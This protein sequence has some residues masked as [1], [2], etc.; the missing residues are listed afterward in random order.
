MA[1]CVIGLGY[2][3]LTLSLKLVDSG[4]EVYGL[5]RNPEIVQRLLLG[6]LHINEPGL[7][8]LLSKHLGKGF[9]PSTE[10]PAPGQASTHI[11]CVNTPV[12]RRA[13]PDLMPLKEAARQVSTFISRG[14]LVVVRSTIPPGC[15]RSVVLPQLER[16]KMRCG[17]DLYL[18][19]APERTV[20]GQ[21]LAELGKL[22][23]IIGGLDPR[24]ALKA[25]RFFAKITPKLRVVSS[26]E[27]AEMTKL[28]DNSYR[29]ATFAI[30]NELGLA[31]EAMGLDGE[32]VI[33]AA[34]WQYPRN[35]IKLPGAGVGG[36]CLPKDSAILRHAMRRAGISPRILEAARQVN[37]GMPSKVLQHIDGFH[38][39]HGIRP[40]DS[41]ILVLGFAFKG[42]PKVNDTRHSPGGALCRMLVEK[43]YG[44]W[45]YDPAV[46]TEKIR[47]FGAV[48]CSTVEEGFSRA[49]CIV[50]MN[51]NPMWSRL[52]LD[53]L[54][55]LQSNSS[56][57]MDGWRV[58]REPGTSKPG[59]R[60]RR[61]GNG[62]GAPTQ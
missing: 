7:K 31:C 49:T 9:V 34:N 54:S 21:A 11:L 24:S 1:T 13:R 27:A 38:Q 12:G 57:I 14:D 3:G 61:L 20:E 15:T 44:V 25:K 26:L 39:E 40:Q 47:A 42:R 2:V 23:Q 41:K 36:G 35:N 4:E 48:P 6:K 43:G 10:P 56:L 16:S 62:R 50:A 28:L 5:E 51:D 8:P 32:E 55:L 18:A 45:G 19:V 58:L 60:F 33:K 46:E 59:V 37:E 29:Y 53:A 22:P 30:G 52:D 17:T